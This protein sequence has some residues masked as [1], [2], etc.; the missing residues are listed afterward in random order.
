MH[1]GRKNAYEILM[2]K[3]KE[4]RPLRKPRLRWEDDIRMDLREIGRDVMERIHLSQDRNQW[5]FS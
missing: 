4:K 3:P 5:R 2:G 1:G